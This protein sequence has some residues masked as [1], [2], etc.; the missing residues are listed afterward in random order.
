V[1]SGRPSKIVL[2]GTDIDDN[3]CKGIVMIEPGMLEHFK[4]LKETLRDADFEAGDKAM[5]AIDW[6]S[7]IQLAIDGSVEAKT[8]VS[9][10]AE[11]LDYQGRFEDALKR[12]V[13]LAEPI[14]RRLEKIRETQTGP[15]DK[16]GRVDLKSNIWILIHYAMACY[17]QGNYDRPRKM[18][19]LGFA[20]C[21]TW[22][23]RG[24]EYSCALTKA[25]IH[26]GFGL[27]YREEQHYDEARREF[28]SGVQLSWPR[29]RELDDVSSSR[30]LD[31][32]DADRKPPSN[33][34]AL[35]LTRAVALGLAYLYQLLDCRGG[36]FRP[37]NLAERQLQYFVPASA[38]TGHSRPHHE[39]RQNSHTLGRLFIGI[40]HPVSTD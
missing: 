27:I 19:R 4:H 39:V 35:A 10:S 31:D 23:D 21:E 12:I 40:K 29:M 34:T 28:L 33:W 3:F 1:Q 15:T 37:K 24:L 7:A 30:H 38:D 25:R 14:L 36:H 6:G 2:A 26:Y 5:N 18:L 11:L 13:P 22:L 9:M 8:A 20:L 16:A 32:G 17:R